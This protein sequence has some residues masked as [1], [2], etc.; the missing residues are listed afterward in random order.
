MVREAG[1]N[2]R[3]GERREHHASCT[4]VEVQNQIR[5]DPA[6]RD[7]IDIRVLFEDRR[8]PG[9]HHN[10]D[11]QIG[12]VRLEQ[13]ERGRGQDNDSLREAC[14]KYN[15]LVGERSIDAA[16]PFATMLPAPGS[17]G[18]VRA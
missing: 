9:F 6:F 11:F 8:E 17:P 2:L 7:F 5:P 4:A 10:R 14:G 13:R 18:E 15:A 16:T 1:P 3:P 12:A